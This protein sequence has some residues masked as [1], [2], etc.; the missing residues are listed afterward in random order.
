M[1]R[2]RRLR[3]LLAHE[4]LVYSPPADASTA[5]AAG[6]PRRGRDAA[7]PARPEEDGTT[8]PPPGSVEGIFYGDPL[9][10]QSLAITIAGLVDGLAAMDGIGGDEASRRAMQRAE[11]VLSSAMPT[12]PRSVRPDSLRAT[13]LVCA[14]AWLVLRSLE[15]RIADAR[16]GGE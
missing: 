6:S 3:D 4:S 8:P 16:G 9:Y 5:A 11:R 1:S 13:A 14:A 2:A 7:P 15:R 10:R 12:L